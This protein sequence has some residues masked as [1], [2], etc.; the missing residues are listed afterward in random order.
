MSV[1]ALRFPSFTLQTRSEHQ[2]AERQEDN[3]L[4]KV[5]HRGRGRGASG[6]GALGRRLGGVGVA[7]SFSKAKRTRGREKSAKWR[8]DDEQKP[9]SAATKKKKEKRTLLGG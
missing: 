3:H 9:R 6:E 8:R 5:L 4:G 1:S 2:S 7:L